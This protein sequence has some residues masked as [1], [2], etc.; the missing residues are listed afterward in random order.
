M[1]D[2]PTPFNAQLSAFLD[3]LVQ[4]EERLRDEL[5]KTRELRRLVEAQLSTNPFIDFINELELP[6]E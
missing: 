6:G 5:I 2:T 3:L 4:H 1:S